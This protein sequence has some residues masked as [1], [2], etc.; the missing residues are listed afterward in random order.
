LMA[1]DWSSYKAIDPNVEV[2]PETLPLQKYRKSLDAL[3]QIA[4]NFT[5]YSCCSDT[6]KAEKMI[7]VFTDPQ[8]RSPLFKSLNN[9]YGEVVAEY[10]QQVVP[11][12]ILNNHAVTVRRKTF[13]LDYIRLFYT[14]IKNEFDNLVS[15]L[16][17]FT[18]GLKNVE[19]FSDFILNST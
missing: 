5:L 16:R 13:S 19:Q 1:L 10:D 14:D 9:L 6:K 8:M 11:F 15:E 3:R 2:V 4:I 12:E 17:K 18:P 7:K